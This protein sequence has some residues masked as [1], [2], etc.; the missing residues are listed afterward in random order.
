MNDMNKHVFLTDDETGEEIEFEV[1]DGVEVEEERF[2]LVVPLKDGME[3]DT[4]FIL[5]DISKN[6]SEAVYQL[7]EDDEEFN[8]AAVY[9]TED[10]NEY[11]IKF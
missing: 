9:F 4:A 1:I 11:E 3:K 10:N 6:N 7:V 8:K 2:L 5:K